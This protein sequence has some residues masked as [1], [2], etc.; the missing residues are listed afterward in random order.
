MPSHQGSFDGVM[1]T[2]V[3]MVLERTMR[4]PFGLV[5][6]LVFGATPKKPRSGLTARS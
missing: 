4:M 1:T 3:K 5:A 6:A 2:L